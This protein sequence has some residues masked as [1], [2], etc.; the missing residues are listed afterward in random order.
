[1]RHPFVCIDCDLQ[2]GPFSGQLNRLPFYKPRLLRSEKSISS[3][4]TESVTIGKKYIQKY[5]A[6]QGK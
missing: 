3:L 4:Q 5:W 1:M 6:E 2:E